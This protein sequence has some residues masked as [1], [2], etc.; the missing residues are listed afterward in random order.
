MRTFSSGLE[1]SQKQTMLET[2][3]TSK[4]NKRDTQDWLEKKKLESLPAFSLQNKFLEHSFTNCGHRFAPTTVLKRRRFE[5]KTKQMILAATTQ[6]SSKP[7]EG[8]S[9]E[10]TA[11]KYIRP[12]PCE[13]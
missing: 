3:S 1:P 12:N 4:N 5:S 11:Y 13:S 8:H 9:A 2:G 6:L 10:E 7:V